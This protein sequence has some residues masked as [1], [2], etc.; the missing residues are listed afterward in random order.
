MTTSQSKTDALVYTAPRTAMIETVPLEAT[1]ETSVL[2]RSTHGLISRGTE[3]LVFEGRVPTGEYDRMRAP[4]QVGEFPF[5]VRYGYALS[6]VVEDGPQ[7][8]IGKPVFAL[9][10]HQTRAL[11]PAEMVTPVPE[12]VPLA[13]SVLAA[14]METAMNA[15]WDARLAPGMRCLV[16]GVGLVGWLIAVRLSI[17]QDLDTTLTDI[18]PEAGIK[19]D[20]FNVSFQ[21]PDTVP[22]GAFDVVFHTSASAGGLATGLEALR[23]EGTLVE[24]SWYGDRAVAVPLG[25]AFHANRL[26]IL[27]SQ[28]GHVAN[29]R[30]GAMSRRERLAQAMAALADPR[31]DALITTDAA[32]GDLPRRL[33]DLLSADAPGIAT[34]IIYPAA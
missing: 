4:L 16:I 18:R 10:P 21:H 22:R 2:I 13:R 34:R 25:G 15:I 33:G 6:G 30:R 1:D 9:H 32:F 17:R 11:V 23:F 29:P 12:T 5:P 31:F 20:D 8:L 19:A 7:T 28:V 24:L 3:R 27:S 26:R 14:N